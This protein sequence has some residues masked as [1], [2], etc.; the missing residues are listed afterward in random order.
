MLYLENLWNMEGDVTNHKLKDIN[1]IEKQAGAY[2]LAQW[3]KPLLLIL[4]PSNTGVLVQTLATVLPVELL[5]YQY[6][7]EGGTRGPNAWAPATHMGY[8]NVNHFS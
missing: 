5:A 8:Q 3:D 4:P 1:P 2:A 6:T 7:W